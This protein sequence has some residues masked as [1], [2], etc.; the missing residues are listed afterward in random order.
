MFH[1]KGTHYPKQY[2]MTTGCDFVMKEQKVRR[3]KLS[4]LFFSPCRPQYCT[5]LD[6]RFEARADLWDCTQKLHA[7]AQCGMPRFLASLLLMLDMPVSGAVFT[8]SILLRCWF[9]SQVSESGTTVELHIYD[10]SGQTVFKELTAEYVSL[11]LL[12]PFLSS[13]SPSASLLSFSLISSR[14]SPR[15]LSP[16]ILSPS[17][18]AKP[19]SSP[20]THSL[21]LSLSALSLSLS[22]S[23]LSLSL[24]LSRFSLGS[25]S[26]SLSLASKLCR[27]NQSSGASISCHV[28]LKRRFLA[29]IPVEKRKLPNASLRRLQPRSVNYLPV[30]ILLRTPVLTLVY[31]ATHQ[32]GHA[33]VLQI[34]CYTYLY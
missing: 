17:S 23:P 33:G 30:C 24:S 9:R 10:C 34:S 19:I 6:S 14:C 31:L 7:A 15:S 27:R 21:A 28:V 16:L 8:R 5:A 29:F 26:L 2:Q 12:S 25:I 11:P 3:P 32:Y 18:S 13:P 20:Q 1:S 4:H 22:L